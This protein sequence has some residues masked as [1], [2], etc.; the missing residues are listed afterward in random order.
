MFRLIKA[1]CISFLLLS[2][3]SLSAW[4]TKSQDPCAQLLEG[5]SLSVGDWFQ[6]AFKLGPYSPK[7]LIFKKLKNINRYSLEKVKRLISVNGI[8]PRK[9]LELKRDASV[10]WVL[11]DDPLLYKYI[12][13]AKNSEI[14][15]TNPINYPVIE[16]VVRDRRWDVMDQY[17]ANSIIYH[18]LTGA[19]Y[20]GYD[21]IVTHYL[22]DFRLKGEGKPFHIALRFEGHGVPDGFLFFAEWLNDLAI[23]QGVKI[24][25]LTATPETLSHF[26]TPNGNSNGVRKTLLKLDQ[27]NREDLKFIQDT[28]RVL[29]GRA[30]LNLGQIESIV[31]ITPKLLIKDAVKRKV[32]DFESGYAYAAASMATEEEI[33]EL[34]AYL[35]DSRIAKDPATLEWRARVAT[36]TKLGRERNLPV[37]ERSIR[38]I[39]NVQMGVAILAEYDMHRGTNYA[40]IVKIR[41]DE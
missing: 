8:L 31:K 17:L 23:R 13:E 18:A 22:D 7:S 2:I 36:G 24:I 34:G 6:R 28:D 1:F 19:E 11:L 30:E 3:F 16:I 9:L 27:V 20:A 25:A 21:S 5:R 39:E 37:H 15:A 38:F 4:C 10:D 29:Q 12:V 41:I 35:R 14:P 26:R 32:V 40:G 33:L